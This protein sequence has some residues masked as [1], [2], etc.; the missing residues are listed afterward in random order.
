MNKQK[1]KFNKYGRKELIGHIA[2]PLFIAGIFFIVAGRI[3]LYRVWIWAVANL[4]YYVGGMMVILKVNPQLFNERGSWNRKKDTKSWDK[5]IL[6]L[7]GTIGLYGHTIIMALDV[8]RYE[9]SSLNSWFILP[10]MILFTGG[11]NLVYWSMAV[12]THFETSVR[13]QHD[14]DHKVVSRGPYQIVRHPGYLGLMI[15]NFGAAMIIGSFYGCL[16]ALATLVILFIRTNL[17]DRTLIAEL[18]GYSEYTKVTKYRL[19]PF[20]W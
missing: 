17:E 5:V 9:W 10:G 19:I 8:G 4:V 12:N 15:T 11:F 3:D 16:T 13:I 2:G 14:R 20:V 6:T 7:F 18:D 1:V